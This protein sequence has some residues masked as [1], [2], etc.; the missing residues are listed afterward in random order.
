[1]ALEYPLERWQ[2]RMAEHIPGANVAFDLA[3]AP[4]KVS[5]TAEGLTCRRGKGLVQPQL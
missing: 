4:F 3:K 1:M 5:M 2:W